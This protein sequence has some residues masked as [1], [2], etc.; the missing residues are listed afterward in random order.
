MLAPTDIQDQKFKKR[1]GKLEQ[2]FIFKNVNKSHAATGN[3]A[4][5]YKT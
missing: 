2:V 3:T 4:R 1:N 5:R